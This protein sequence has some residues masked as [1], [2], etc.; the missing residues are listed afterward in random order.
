MQDAGAN[1]TSTS[2]LTAS[3]SGP[4]SDPFGGLSWQVT[5]GNQPGTATIRGSWTAVKWRSTCIGQ[6]FASSCSEFRCNFSYAI[7]QA[8]TTA[9]SQIP[10]FFVALSV[11]N[12]NLGC[13]SP[14]VGFGAK[15]EYQVA[16]Q[17]KMPIKKS[18]MTPLELVTV[19]DDAGNVVA[20]G[21]QYLSFSTPVTTRNDG[22]FTDIPIG[23]CRNLA[24]FPGNACFNVTQ[25][26]RIA[27]PTSGGGGTTYEISTTTIRRDCAQG[28]KVDVQHT[29]SD[30]QSFTLGTVN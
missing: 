11:T 19:I 6:S 27:V 1:V 13:T 4:F 21:N 23:T 5:L 14:L 15:V 9:K 10:K 2:P 28:I 16:D 22:T 7:G 24:A 20:Q 8:S 18:G 3:V 12:S 17:D 25:L 30:V 29:A 26:F